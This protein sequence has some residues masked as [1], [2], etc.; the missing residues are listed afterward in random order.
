M[1]NALARAIYN[2]ANRKKNESTHEL[3][4]SNNGQNQVIGHLNKQ[5][6][7]FQVYRREQGRYSG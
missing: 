4:N 5:P 1:V 2:I 6:E 7:P 3:L